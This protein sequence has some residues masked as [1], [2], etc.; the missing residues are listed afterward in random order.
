[1]Y[2]NVELNC[3]NFS[4]RLS[5]MY[6]VST[7][8]ADALNSPGIVLLIFNPGPVLEHVSIRFVMKHP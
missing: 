4:K 7:A 1:M 6:H 3:F 5:V 8:S 2:S